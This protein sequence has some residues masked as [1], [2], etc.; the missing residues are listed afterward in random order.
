MTIKILGCSNRDLLTPRT[1]KE[2]LNQTSYLEVHIHIE[3]Y[4]NQGVLGNT[5]INQGIFSSLTKISVSSNL[6]IA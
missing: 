3:R 1:R 4:V 5:H 2:N 6:S